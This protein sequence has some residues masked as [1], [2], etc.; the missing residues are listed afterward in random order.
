MFLENLKTIALQVLI[1]YLI[2][3]VGFVTDKIGI[4]SQDDG[5]RLIDLL[6]NVILPIAIIRTFINMEY[7]PEHV[8]GIFIA[9]ACAMG[10]HLFGAIV[11]AFTFRKRSLKERG[12]YHYGMILSNAAFLALPL[13]KSVIG[14]EGIF[15]CSVYVAVFNMV[16][17]TYGIYEISGHEAK[18]DFKR[19][20]FN[21]G[22]ISVIIGLPLFFLQPDIPY[23]IDYPMELIGNCNSP[24]AM[25]VFGTFLANS[26]FK[27]LLMKKE[28]YF[29]SFIRLVLIPLCM[30]GIFYLCGVRGDLL[31]AM[32][33]SSAAPTA[34]NTAMYAAK[35]DNDT[36]LGAE[37]AAQTSVFSIVTMPVIVALASVV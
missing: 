19:L 16:A 14:D 35:Y 27:N 9:F 26:N 22:S 25:I 3:G 13:A 28:L 32:I 30:L 33:I 8:K 5:K 29:T 11:S 17:F 20:I 34:T 24:L 2:A 12:I 23:F 18:I 10:T 7:T 36:A 1:L 37:I 4:F 21:P 6:F 31:T 15:Y